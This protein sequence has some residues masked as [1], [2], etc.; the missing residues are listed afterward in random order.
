MLPGNPIP[1]KT[2]YHAQQCAEKY[3]KGFL[4]STSHSFNFVHDLFYLTQKCVATS[5]RFQRSGT[6]GRDVGQVRR[7]SALSDGKFRRSG[8]RRSLG[9]NKTCRGS[10]NLCKEPTLLP[11]PPSR[12][13][14]PFDRPGP[15][16]AGLVPAL[17]PPSR[18]D[19]PFDRPGPVGAG[20]VPALA[21]PSRV[22]SPFHRPGPVGAGLVPALCLPCA[23]PQ[24]GTQYHPPPPRI[25]HLTFLAPRMNCTQTA[26]DLDILLGKMYNRFYWGHLF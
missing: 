13:D 1:P 20:L 26:L 10:R 11:W 4:V 25:P 8:R 16:G 3:L 18:V 7:R 24:A 9:S 17:A 21:P 14:S 22:D 23:S 15:V 12:V 19:S 5:A 6:G 2:C